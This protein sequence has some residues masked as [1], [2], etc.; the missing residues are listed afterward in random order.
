M[1]RVQRPGELLVD[2]GDGFRG[3]VG[4]RAGADVVLNCLEH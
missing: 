4:A 3:L 1:K 2:V